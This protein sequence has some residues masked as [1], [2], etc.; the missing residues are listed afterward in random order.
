MIRALMNHALLFALLGGWLGVTQAAADPELASEVSDVATL[1]PNPPHR[2]FTGGFREH[3]FVI[4]D[5]DT[6]KMEGSIPAGYVSNLAIAPDNSRFYVSETYWT[7]GARGTRQ[8]LVSIYDAKTLNLLKEISLPGR[9]LVEKMQNFDINASGSRAYVYVMMP[10]ASVVWVDL[11]AQAVGGTVEIP[12]CALVFPW[13]NDGFSSLCGDG[14]LASVTIPAS[15]PAKVTHTKSFFD[16]NSDPI[17]ENSFV[18]R[19]TGKAIFISYTGLVY[20]AQ[21]GADTK[22]SEPWSIQ[23][24]AGYA[25]AGTGVQELAWRPGGDQVAAYH[26]ASGKLFV[27]MHPGNYWTHKHGGTEIWVLDTKAHTLLLR[28]P[29]RPVPSSG[30]GWDPVPYYT[31]IGVSQ[32]AKP[33]LYLLNP[34]GNDV[35]LD[36]TTGAE[37]RKIEFAAGDWVSVPGN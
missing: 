36:G 33:L 7:H 34:E 14:S 16:A 25:P 23:K 31:S 3:S 30:L 32:D 5:A 6:G 37:L 29:L 35:V 20:P 27:L 12:G 8:D 21:L 4:F 13:G 15:G 22:V 18:D 11:K 24:A 28:I 19:A 2:F 9:A 26:K 17:F 10:V 1:P